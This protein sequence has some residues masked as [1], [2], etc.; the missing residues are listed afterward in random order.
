MVSHDPRLSDTTVDFC[1][2]ILQSKMSYHLFSSS[3]P[4]FISHDGIFII[5]LLYWCIT[6][7]HCNT[8]SFVIIPV[9]SQNASK[10]FVRASRG[11]LTL[12][13]A[14]D[15]DT[16][17]RPT[18][19]LDFLPRTSNFFLLTFTSNGL[20]LI[21]WVVLALRTLSARFLFLGAFP[22]FNGGSS[23]LM[24]CH[25]LRHV[26]ECTITHFVQSQRGYLSVSVLVQT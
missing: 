8:N 5:M 25:Q 17:G 26:K 19:C 22:I 10:D 12:V 13:M 20:F 2:L 9:T 7:P 21:S 14:L 18:S 1:F 15:R 11:S 3:V 16:P 24:S 6:V 4:A 23:R